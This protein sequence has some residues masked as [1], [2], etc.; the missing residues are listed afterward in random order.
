MR[1]SRGVGKGTAGAD[2]T[3]VR[4]EA[5]AP[6]PL[7]IDDVLA[8]AVAIS[9]V[10]AQN[11]GAFEA[12]SRLGLGFRGYICRVESEYMGALAIS[13]IDGQPTFQFERGMPKIRYPYAGDE[14]KF[15]IPTDAGITSIRFYEKLDGTNITALP[16]RDPADPSR[17]LEV[18]YKT[19]LKPVLSPSKWGDFGAL[20]DRVID[21]DAVAA[22]V[23][24]AGFNLAFELWGLANP[25][26]ITADR[27]LALTLHTGI[28]PQG[29]ASPHELDVLAAKY[30]LE[31]PQLH[32]ELAGADLEHGRIAAAYQRLRAE[33]EARNQAAGKDV[34]VTEG[35]I[36]CISTASGAVY[37][38][39]KP[40]T[41]EEDHMM[42]SRRLKRSIVVQSVHKLEEEGYD[43]DQGV[44]GLIEV[45]C[46]EF[47]PAAVAVAQP[48]LL[49]EFG[50]FQ[51]V[52]AMR[53]EVASVLDAANPDPADKN[54]CMRILGRHFADK[55]KMTGAYQGYERWKALRPAT[56]V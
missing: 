28:R 9:G 23:E 49:D 38:K 29:L 22:A 55:T 7:A 3:I 20:L 33:A 44:S 19:R 47:D 48:M 54:A 45:L 34:F 15:V 39:C 37:L 32:L 52:L 24:E 14:K 4:P 17:I 30:G 56:T 50:K 46:R 12:T 1:Y 5:D 10:K 13:E 26:Q 16:L 8:R 53:A 41:I 35:S 27:G 2:R 6:G 40:E 18:I 42:R 21:Y 11:W 31:R 51:R 36:M 43:F 25:H